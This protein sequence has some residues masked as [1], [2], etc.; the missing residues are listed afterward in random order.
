[1][2]AVDIRSYTTTVLLL[3]G[4]QLTKT[5]YVQQMEEEKKMLLCLAGRC[6]FSGNI[7]T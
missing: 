2:I 1:M 3:T 5:Q 4:H 6:K 7:V